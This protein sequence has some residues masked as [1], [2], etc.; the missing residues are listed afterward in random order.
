MGGLGGRVTH[1]Y[2]TGA[3]GISRKRRG[4]V[5][6]QWKKSE[7][8]RNLAQQQQQQQKCDVKCSKVEGG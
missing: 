1:R 2:I 7:I 4:V 5:S 3:R 8:R 6:G